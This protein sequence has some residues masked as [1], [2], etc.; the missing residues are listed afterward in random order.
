MTP[1][2]AE[3]LDGK[4]F[5]AWLEGRRPDLRTRFTD[6]E[7]RTLYRLR[8]ENGRA[9]LAVADRLCVRLNVH[10]NEIPQW[11]WLPPAK[12]AANRVRSVSIKG[13]AVALLA[14]GATVQETAAELKLSTRTVSE[15]RREAIV[16]RRA[17]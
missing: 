9:S 1:A 17:A 16:R 4:A 2:V 10:L 5:A 12:D 11:V 8:T 13:E 7:N 3:W 6:S 14:D 15:W